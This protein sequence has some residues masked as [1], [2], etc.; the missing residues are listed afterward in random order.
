MGSASMYEVMQERVLEQLG[1]TE[2]DLVDED[3]L[4]H[5]FKAVEIFPLFEGA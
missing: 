4:M 2:A 3:K 1:M 5:F